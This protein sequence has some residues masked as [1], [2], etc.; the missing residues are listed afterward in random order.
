MRFVVQSLE[1]GRFLCPSLADGQPEWV[2]SLREAGGGVV[3]DE[4]EALDMAIEYAEQGE[5]VQVIDLDRLGTSDDYSEG[6]R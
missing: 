1:T 4:D 5:P 2:R 3:T 6:T